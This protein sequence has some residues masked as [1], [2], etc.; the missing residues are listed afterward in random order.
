MPTI[1][2]PLSIRLPLVTCPSLASLVSLSTLFRQLAATS[3]A[4][5]R[6]SLREKEPVSRR[7]GHGVI[8]VAMHTNKTVC[9][10]DDG[11]GFSRK[12]WMHVKTNAWQVEGA[13]LSRANSRREGNPPMYPQIARKYNL[14]FFMVPEPRDLGVNHVPR[15]MPD[16]SSLLTVA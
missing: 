5:I 4:L 1:V 10:T 3:G 2:A 9:S 15:T 8:H 7:R 6:G 16:K 11:V 13:R 14:I 12:C